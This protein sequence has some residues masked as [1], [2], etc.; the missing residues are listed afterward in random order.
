MKKYEITTEEYEAVVKARKAAQ[1]KR[2]A[3]RL[4]Q[5]IFS[6]ILRHGEVPAVRPSVQPIHAQPAPV[7]TAAHPV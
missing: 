7:K 2:T 1:N 6:W 3:R 4:P 5:L